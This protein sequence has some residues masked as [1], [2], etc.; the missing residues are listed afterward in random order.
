MMKR[1]AAFIAAALL[2]LSGC[3]AK[4]SS[5]VTAQPPFWVAEN[6][7]NGAVIYMLGTMHVGE[8]GVT[9]P[10]YI[11]A[12]FESCD[13]VAVEI[14]TEHFSDDELLSAS[15]QLLLRD[16]MTAK[17]CFGDDYDE[18]VSFLTEKGVYHRS[19]EIYIPYYWSSALT[20]LIAE[21]CGLSSDYGTESIFIDMAWEQNKKVIEI[22]SLA[23]QYGMMAEIPMSVQVDTVLS[24][25]G[26]E[27]YAEQVTATREMY[28][29]W[30]HFDTEGLE[31]L[32]EELESVSA[33][34]D[35][36]Y[37]AFNDMMY[38]ERQARMADFAARC[39]ENGK[40]VFMMVGAAH[41]F[42]E[43]DIITLLEDSGYTVREIRA[44]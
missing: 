37:E 4:T 16:G 29:D 35:E 39:L 41:F 26:E 17:D 21:D 19:M 11:T 9:Y 38:I 20:M 2:L 5:E 13:M 22:E 40:K 27:N 28:E 36:D 34:L 42:I 10:E 12:A 23:E 25:I 18:V 1:S 7:E 15:A 30:L 33:E 43:D 32:N 8:K 24:G 14:D 44:E 3:A 31:S 6:E